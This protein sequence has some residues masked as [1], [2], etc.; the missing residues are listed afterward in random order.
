MNSQIT[1]EQAE[2]LLMF[3]GLI[4]TAVVARLVCLAAWHKWFSDDAEPDNLTQEERDLR[5]V[6]RRGRR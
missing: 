5:R 1:P 6:Q 3:A 2:L 4:L